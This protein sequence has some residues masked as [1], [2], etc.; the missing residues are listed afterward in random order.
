MPS[1]PSLGAA[2]PGPLLPGTQ[3]SRPAVFGDRGMSFNICRGTLGSLVMFT[4][5]RNALS[6]V[7]RLAAD[8][9]QFSAM[10]NVANGPSHHPAAALQS[11]AFTG[12][13][14]TD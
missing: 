6:H 14:F 5:N 9:G 13:A 10:R 8:R 2:Q 7:C 11:V 12:L 1:V 4:A 3:S